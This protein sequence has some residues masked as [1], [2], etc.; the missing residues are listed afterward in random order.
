MKQV[1][2]FIDE[3]KITAAVKNH[4][5]SEELAIIIHPYEKIEAY[6]T[7]LVAKEEGRFW[8]SHT[9][10]YHLHSIIPEKR[11]ICTISPVQLMKAVKNKTEIKGMIDCH[12]R[13]AAALCIYF[14]WLEKTISRETV[15]EV[16]G[17]DKLE[18]IRR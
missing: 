1:H 14:A 15:T 9:S 2:L 4:F 13:D 17:A 18:E 7:D 12:I 10:N 11:R 5:K 8:L 6:L 16:S 3:S